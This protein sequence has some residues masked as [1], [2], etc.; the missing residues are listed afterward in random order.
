M[1][2][3]MSRVNDEL[4]ISKLVDERAELKKQLNE[5][6]EKLSQFIIEYDGIMKN[7]A[8]EADVSVREVIDRTNAAAIRLR[9]EN[10]KLQVKCDKLV[11]M[12]NDFKFDY[13]EFRLA[14]R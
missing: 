1:S 2:R 5:V 6:K 10:Y 7:Y 12:F 3:D 4:E 8:L 11:E 14:T 9:D 13:E